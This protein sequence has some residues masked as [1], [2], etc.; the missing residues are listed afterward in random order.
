MLLNSYCDKCGKEVIFDDTKEYMYCWSCGNMIYRSAV[1]SAV[2]HAAPAQAVPVQ[3]APAPVQMVPV[4]LVPVPVQTYYTGPNLIVSYQSSN[5]R[6]PMFFRIHTTN[7]RINI[8][9]GQTV[10]FNLNPGR[11]ALFFRIGNKFYRRDI[12]II[13]GNAPVRAECSWYGR[14]RIDIIQ[15]SVVYTQNM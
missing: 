13:A 9:P 4:N 6:F 5:Q 1:Q 8:E 12:R 10:S 2:A 3:A 14:A 11:H 15:S 7:E